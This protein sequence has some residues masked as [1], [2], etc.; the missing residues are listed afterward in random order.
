VTLPSLSNV[1]FR[2]VFRSETRVFNTFW[3]NNKFLGLF[4]PAPSFGSF[5]VFSV[6][7]RGF[8][9]R[10]V[11]FLGKALSSFPLFSAQI[12]HF[13]GSTGLKL[14]FFSLFQD[15]NQFLGFLPSS[16]PAPSSFGDFW[17]F[18]AN[19]RDFFADGALLRQHTLSFSP[20]QPKFIVVF[21][22]SAGIMWFSPIF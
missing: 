3:D 22:N 18:Q 16:P 6:E 13:S 19:L 8:S 2:V 11:P 5:L 15:N 4:S 20:F 10:F 21:W 7:L 14:G 17:L 12:L 1:V 9:C